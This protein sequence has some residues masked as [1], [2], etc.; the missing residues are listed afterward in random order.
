MTHSDLSLSL[1]C[2][3]DASAIA[4]MSRVLIEYGLQ[5]KWTAQRVE[6]SIC[7]ANVNVLV[8]RLESRIIGFAIMRYGDDD[9]HLD[10]LAVAPQYRRLGVGQELLNW[11]EKCAGVAGT[12]RITLEV[13]ENNRGAQQFYERM[14]YHRLNLVPGYYEGREAALRMR[15]DLASG[16]GCISSSI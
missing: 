14:G 13:R 7:A 15:R 1:A 3:S 2:R 5:W 10:L 12:F 16:S 6:A 4:R 11:L 8:A 9:A